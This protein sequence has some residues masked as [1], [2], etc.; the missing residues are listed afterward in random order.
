MTPGNLYRLKRRTWFWEGPDLASTSPPVGTVLLYLERTNRG[1]DSFLG[2]QG[3][4]LVADIGPGKDET[5]YEEV[6]TE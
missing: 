5:L 6:D 1:Y 2:P 4:K 3:K